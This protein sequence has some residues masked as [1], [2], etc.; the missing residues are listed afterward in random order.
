M[1]TLPFFICLNYPRH[2][3]FKAL[4]EVVWRDKLKII[5]DG[6]S[7]WLNKNVLKQLCVTPVQECTQAPSIWDCFRLITKV[8]VRAKAIWITTEIVNSKQT[9][10]LSWL[11]PWLLHPHY[12]CQSYYHHQPLPKPAKRNTWPNTM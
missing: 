2:A 4:K 7:F 6:V 10:T 12:N 5:I 1:R 3:S 9:L 8:Y 11:F